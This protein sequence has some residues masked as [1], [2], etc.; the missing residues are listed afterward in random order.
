MFN[1][2]CME[3]RRLSRQKSTYI[4]LLTA[5]V[6]LFLLTLVLNLSFT[7]LESL[8]NSGNY[9]EEKDGIIFEVSLNLKTNHKIFEYGKE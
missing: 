9:S 3:L 2:T 5:A 4:I 6:T 1:F 8:D 7:A